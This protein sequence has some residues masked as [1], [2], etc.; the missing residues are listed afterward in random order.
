[1]RATVVLSVGAALLASTVVDTPRAHSAVPSVRLIQIS[2]NAAGL[3]PNGSSFAPSVSD[4]GRYVAFVSSASDLHPDDS[5]SYMDVFR[6]DTLTG[7]LRLISQSDAGIKAN[8]HSYNP[9]ISGDGRIVAF[10]SDASNLVSDVTSGGNLF[11]WDAA[12]NR[13]TAFVRNSAGVAVPVANASGWSIS[14]NGR[15]VAFFSAQ[16]ILAG[17][18]HPGLYLYDRA[19]GDI[20]RLVEL[21]S[22]GAPPSISADGRWVA[23]SDYANRLPEDRYP[24]ADVYVIDTS[25]GG[26]ELVSVGPDGSQ[27]N[28]SF[29]PSISGDGRYVA[30]Q[31]SSLDRLGPYERIVIKD[32]VSGDLVDITQSAGAPDGASHRPSISA[33]GS[34]VA[35]HSRATNLD[36][37]APFPPIDPG[38]LAP[39]QVYAW[40]RVSGAMTVMSATT[41]TG[42]YDSTQPVVSGDGKSVLFHSRATNLTGA[43]QDLNVYRWSSEAP[44]PY[45]VRGG[46]SVEE[47][48]VAKVTV[49][50]ADASSAVTVPVYRTGTAGSGDAALP[51]AISFVAGQRTA[52]ILL[53]VTDDSLAEADEVVLVKVGDG[54]SRVRVV[55][56][57]TDIPDTRITT[58][59]RDTNSSS[60]SV[61]FV[62]LKASEA[63]SVA[64]TLDGQSVGGCTSPFVRRGLLDGRHVLAIVSSVGGRTDPTPATAEWIV[65]STPPSLTLVPDA[66]FYSLAVGENN[67]LPVV[68]VDALT[69][70]PVI[71]VN[72]LSTTTPRAA[73]AS[74][75]CRDDVRNGTT[76]SRRYAV[77]SP[78][79][80]LVAGSA[81]LNGTRQPPGAAFS[82]SI[83]SPPPA[84]ARARFRVHTRDLATGGF[85]PGSWSAG[86]APPFDFAMPPGDDLVKIEAQLRQGATITTAWAWVTIA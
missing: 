49:T 75:T 65:D 82:L 68:C 42:N 8:N 37:F 52:T 78:G 14:A 54:S 27:P 58:A 28:G 64:C 53:K 50:R 23:F 86:K 41:F 20:R 76:I 25:T 40:N 69:A 34:V 30:F 51:T 79:L 18:Y 44:D 74:I 13:T 38:R 73:E 71:T 83:A 16:P 36:P 56:V 9:R 85:N 17:D 12:T 10:A 29:E 84:T 57:D 46:G 1:M 4:D 2:L 31:S 3:Q 70:T 35:F 60:V 62:V 5:D 19:G 26:L 32:R 43:N 22:S 48:A 15:Y 80:S 61:P 67:T 66:D 21:V 77:S 47:G 7:E 24:Y 45:V 63:V 81:A 33:D 72:G 39:F 59:P 11:L 55:I 6:L